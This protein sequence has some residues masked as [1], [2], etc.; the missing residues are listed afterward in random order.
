[1]WIMGKSYVEGMLNGPVGRRPDSLTGVL[2]FR[3]AMDCAVK[4][5]RSPMGPTAAMG[6]A[7]TIPRVW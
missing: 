2:F 3:N 4:S 6:P 7:A 1:M 5:A